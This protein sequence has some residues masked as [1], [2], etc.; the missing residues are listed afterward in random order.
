[1]CGCDVVAASCVAFW[2]ASVFNGDVSL[3][4]TSSVTSMALSKWLC[5]VVFGG[6]WE[7]GRRVCILNVVFSFVVFHFSSFTF[8]F[9]SFS[10]LY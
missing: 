10:S 2:E 6:V 4:D 3:W 7:G 9:L 5:V 1:M 8:P